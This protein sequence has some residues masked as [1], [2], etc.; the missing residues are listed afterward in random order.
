MLLAYIKNK[1]SLHSVLKHRHLQREI[2]E[3]SEMSPKIKS[4]SPSKQTVPM[5]ENAKN[6]KPA[7]QNTT[8]T[9]KEQRREKPE[10]RA[11]PEAQCGQD[12]WGKV[13]RAGSSWIGHKLFST[14]ICF[15]GRL[16]G[17][18]RDVGSAVGYTTLQK[19]EST[20]Y[21]FKK[22][23]NITGLDELSRGKT[24]RIAIEDDW[25]IS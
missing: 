20:K 13:A 3:K 6:S 22:G 2:T 19:L 8:E 18:G 12:D 5:I 10:V 23:I 25:I 16:S 14:F 11:Q 21:P 9:S 24:D 7:S 15:S 1:A 4:L 17:L